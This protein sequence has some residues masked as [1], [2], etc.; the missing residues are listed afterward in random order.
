MSQNDELDSDD[1]VAYDTENS[2]YTT[3]ADRRRREWRDH[4][5]AMKRERRTRRTRIKSRTYT[6][7]LF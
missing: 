2:H 6:L 7:P 5:R 1:I 4:R 3:V